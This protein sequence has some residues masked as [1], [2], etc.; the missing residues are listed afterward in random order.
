VNEVDEGGEE[1][2]GGGGGGLVCVRIN[3]AVD[4]RKSTEGKAGDDDLIKNGSLCFLRSNASIKAMLSH[5]RRSPRE[6]YPIGL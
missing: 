4:W 6:C 2:R 1:S 3:E 5:H